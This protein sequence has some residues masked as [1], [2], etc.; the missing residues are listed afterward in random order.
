MSIYKEVIT[1]KKKQKEEVKALNKVIDLLNIKITE[2]IIQGSIVGYT[3]EFDYGEKIYCG[4]S[5][6]AKSDMEFFSK[7]VGSYIARERAI[8]KLLEDIAIDKEIVENR[9]NC[10]KNYIDAQT[11]FIENIK[12]QRKRIKQ[13]LDP[14]PPKFIDLD[15]KM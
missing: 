5:T 2:N 9:K 8:I 1:I 11:Y 15:K 10:L 12:R 3:A 14:I 13:G 6:C 4:I 7:T